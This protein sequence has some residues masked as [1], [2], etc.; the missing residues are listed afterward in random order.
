[1]LNPQTTNLEQTIDLMLSEVRKS[2]PDR[3]VLHNLP[4]GRFQRD[5]FN[6]GDNDAVT[7]CA[8]ALKG[9]AVHLLEMQNQ[10]DAG[11]FRK[12]EAP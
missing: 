7:D 5:S 6:A 10:H 2:C 4:D 8:F 11:R 1:M 9:L 3:W 12:E